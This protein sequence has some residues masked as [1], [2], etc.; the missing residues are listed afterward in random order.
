MSISNSIWKNLS[1]YS[2]PILLLGSIGYFSFIFISVQEQWEWGGGAKWSWVRI[3]ILP[4]YSE[5]ILMLRTYIDSAAYSTQHTQQLHENVDIFPIYCWLV[6]AC[7]KWALQKTY[8]S[9]FCCNN[10]FDWIFNEKS[11][12]QILA[13]IPIKPGQTWKNG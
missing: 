3:S 10:N 8:K 13:S 5:V 1:A 6:L 4:Y 2:S 12:L 11:N 9:N 7:S